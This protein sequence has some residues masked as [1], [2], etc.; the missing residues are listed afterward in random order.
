M[1]NVITHIYRQSLFK[2][3]S[4]YIVQCSEFTWPTWNMSIIYM[5]KSSVFMRNSQFQIFLVNWLDFTREIL[6]C[7]SKCDCT[8][9]HIKKVIILHRVHCFCNLTFLCS[10][11]NG[12][13]VKWCY[14]QF[15]FPLRGLF[16]LFKLSFVAS[17]WRMAFSVRGTVETKAWSVSSPSRTHPGVL[18]I[19]C[20]AQEALGEHPGMTRL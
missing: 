6:Q 19:S 7:S 17:P 15:D 9:K 4:Y 8:F 2:L 18:T 10:W 14:R 12:A 13:N 11:Q 5:G 16:I 3:Y 1:V 20:M